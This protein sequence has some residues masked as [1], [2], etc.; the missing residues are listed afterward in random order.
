[1]HSQTTL[2]MLILYVNKVY[3]CEVLLLTSIHLHISYW[4][5]PISAGLLQAESPLPPF[6]G[7]EHP[8]FTPPSSNLLI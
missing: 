2:K 4:N 5:S 7:H 3:A 8:K 1:M 6:C